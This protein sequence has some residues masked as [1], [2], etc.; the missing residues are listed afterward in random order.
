MYRTTLKSLLARKWRLV[1]T[2]FAVILGVAFM[3]GTLV[4]TDTMGNTFDNLLADVN[5][6]TDVHVRAELA[7]DGGQQ[8]GDQRPRLD[9]AIID[10]IRSVD[11]VAAADGHIDAYAQLVDKSGE[12]MGNPNMGAPVVGT[13][14][15]QS[16][17]LNPFEL[18]DGRPPTT[19]SDVVIDRGSAKDGDFAVGDPI[20]VL[21]Q[22]GP[23]DATVVGIATFGGE[24]SPGGATFAMFTQPAAQR[25]L[26][27]PGK[28]DAVKVAA[29]EGVTEA[30]L[31]QRIDELL[32]DGIEVL[33]GDEIT[34]QDQD[35][36]A[37][38]LSFFNIFLLVFAII[39]LFVG[40]FI[41]YN[42]FSI[43]VAQRTKE[44]ALLRAIGA[45]R[46]QVTRSVLMEASAV[47][48]IASVI[49]L[50]LGIGVASAL[51]AL[52]E[53]FGVDIPA[54]GVTLTARTVVLSTCAGLGVTL[55]AAVLPARRAAKVPPIAAMRAVAVDQSSSNRRR[56]I[57]G[58]AVAGTG[59]VIMGAGLFGD[60]GLAPIGLGAL[61]VFL[62]V[63]ILGPVMSSPLSRIIGA[64]LPRLSGMPGV[65]AKENAIRNPKRTSA[66]AMALM[67]GVAL[68]GFISILA[69]STKASV[70]NNVE[71]TFT[72]DLVVDSNIAGR[73]GFNP[74][75]ATELAELAEL[76][77][78]TGLRMAP[79]EIDGS[80]AMLTSAD[81]AAL[82]QI[83]DVEVVDGS[84]DALTLDQVAV[85][86]DVASEHQWSLG[87]VVPARFADT[88]VRPLTIAAIYSEDMTV[89]DY[90]INLP[91]FDL[92]VADHFDRQILIKIA[93]GVS[94]D[95]ASAVVE[96]STA[97]HAGAD[98]QDRDAYRKAQ[99]KNLDML[100]NLIYALLG[101]AVLI[102]LL[103]IANT[104][105]LSVFERTS[106]LGLLR[107]VGMTRRQLRATVC[108]ESMIIALLGTTVGLAVGA[109]FGW[110]IVVGLDD[111]GLE[112]FSVPVQ[113]LAIVTLIAVVAGIAAA[114]LPARRAAR[115]DVL[116]AITTS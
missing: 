113:Q 80:A 7:F 30:E 16:E 67:I 83:S 52:L 36:L 64:P 34:R 77:A 59:A 98:V 112:T 51:K 88:G 1:I 108:Y 44:M 109:M 31:A 65:L 75:L 60:A 115:L 110:A 73:G 114:A 76:R 48:L 40:S 66:T 38:D 90:F 91:T 85:H 86:V 47:G 3:A 69:S 9:D 78:V 45:S 5:E 17:T 22:S 82:Q 13:A 68:V 12:P 57:I 26:T 2:S 63:S 11:G 96:R 58:A 55:A 25:F 101:L 106:E 95:E 71:R 41:I 105:A 89:G 42:S 35:A 43:L 104:L 24:D 21:T 62:G 72:G 50:G 4:L 28:I 53:M 10:T 74:E 100:L 54:G 29:E 20:T 46:K 14:W 116:D 6:E 32:P 61:V 70:A 103:G 15:L 107:A 27:E 102:A 18:V 39:A 97:D 37:K 92:H 99:T 87:D 56:L 8:F 81:P 84:L 111:Q 79:I 94:L 93:D 49:G 23:Q 33:T 19:D